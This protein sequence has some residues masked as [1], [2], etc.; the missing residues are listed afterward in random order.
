MGN[1]KDWFE[2]WFNTRYY[3]ILYKN[4][5]I[6]EA[7]KFIEAII[8]YL[9]YKPSKD[10]KVLD[11]ACGKG[12]HS[13]HLS[14]IGFDVTGVDIS[15]KS[16]EFA[17][18]NESNSLKFFQHDMRN[19]FKEN[20]FDIVFN[21]FTSFGYFMTKEED[22]NVLN[23]IYDNLKPNGLFVF[24]FLNTTQV[25]KNLV[26]KEEKIIDGIH[27]S[28]KRFCE[29]EFIKKQIKVL[30]KDKEFNYQEQVKMLNPNALNNL[31]DQ[32]GFKINQ[33]FGNYELNP[34]LEETSNRF[35][36]IAEKQK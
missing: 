11:L 8:K 29:G 4:R 6:D 20:S 5:S 15:K 1:N 23:A 24:D 33:Q 26:P 30:D 19:I 28:I 17:K 27:F 18:R 3:H 32:A 25:V 13:I 10:I 34:F 12:R 36:V 16:I 14:S 9:P 22:L 31:F 21:L 7:N 2:E 35:I